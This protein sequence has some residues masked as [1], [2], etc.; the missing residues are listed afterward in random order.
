[1]KVL[2]AAHEHMH[3]CSLSQAGVHARRWCFTCPATLSH[4]HC[5]R[6]PRERPPVPARRA[7]RQH[8]RPQRCGVAPPGRRRCGPRTA[9]PRRRELRAVAGA[10]AVAGRGA[11]ASRGR[12]RRQAWR[13]HPAPQGRRRQRRAP[14]R[15]RCQLAAAGGRRSGACCHSGRAAGRA[16]ATAAPGTGGHRREQR[17]GRRAG[18]CGPVSQ[19]EGRRRRPGRQPGAWIPLGGRLGVHHD[20]R[21]GPPRCAAGDG[22]RQPLARRRVA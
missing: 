4:M 7:R 21:G 3:C 19:R 8:R 16:A 13:H 17:R 10:G 9:V 1:M 5:P 6:L 2:R 14:W 18:G 20:A 11:G 22:W 12:R 15:R